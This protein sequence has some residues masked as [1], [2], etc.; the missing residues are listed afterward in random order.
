MSS[1]PGLTN[2]IQG[3]IQ[4]LPFR[5][6]MKRIANQLGLTLFEILVAITILS[7]MML[8]VIQFSQTS[9][10]TSERVSREDAEAFQIETAMSRLEWDGS[11]VYSP[12]YFDHKMFPEQMSDRE[13]EAFAQIAPN[14]ER[15][16]RFKNP[17]YMGLPIPLVFSEDKTTL[18]FFS[19]SNRRKRINSKQS[20]FNWVKYSLEQNDL[21]EDTISNNTAQDAE[22]TLML[23]RQIQNT[24]IYN[25][26]RLDWSDTKR[27]ILHRKITSL[28]FEFWDPK[29]FKWQT[30]L[31]VI[32]NGRFIIHGLKATV[33]Y[34]DADNVPITIE[35]IFRPLYP[36][37]TPEN[38]YT[39]L[40]KKIT[41]NNNSQGGQGGTEESENP[42]S[43]DQQ[44]GQIEGGTQQGGQTGGEQ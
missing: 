16:E 27:Q 43:G 23:V 31:R 12:L 37:F 33:E 42:A 7:F 24:D 39:F 38:V 10:D 14:W 26:R 20:N 41:P 15:N 35:R 6:D 40:N 4:T 30:N 25:P 18:S 8:G 32:N 44:G 19:A 28:T 2:Q 1:I 29:Q 13:R 5:E 34:L 21:E 22:P 11:Q 9:L 36:E 17:S 3:L